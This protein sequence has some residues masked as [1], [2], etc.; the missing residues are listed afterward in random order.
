MIKISED[1][2]QTEI[3]LVEGAGFKVFLISDLSGV[4][5]GTLKPSGED[6]VPEDFIGYDYAKD[7][8]ASY[9]ENGKEVHVPEL[10]TDKKDMYAARNFHMENMWYLRVPHQRISR[11]S[12]RFW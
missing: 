7:K 5:D 2:G 9:W 12:T 4:K 10:F 6:F 11:Q 1:G 8:T 3:D